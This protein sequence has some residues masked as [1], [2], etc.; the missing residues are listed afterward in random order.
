MQRIFLA[1]FIAILVAIPLI[2]GTPEFWVNQMNTIGIASLVVLGLVILTG[3]AGMT[4]FGQAAFVGMGAYA[5]AYLSTSL[6]YSPWI[7]LLAGLAIAFVIAYILGQITLRLSGH[8]LP[9]GTIALCLIFYYLFGNMDFLGRHDGLPGIVPIEIFGFSLLKA[10]AIYFLIWGVVLLSIFL[11]LNLLNSRTGRAI[12]A[13]KNGAAM[14]ESFGVNTHHYKMIAFVYAALL[15]S[16]AGW[17]YA[18]EQRAVSPSTFGLNYGI[19][20]LFMAVIGG[21]VSIWG[22]ILGA[23][24][25]VFLRDQIQAYTPY[26][27]DAKVNV[28]MVVFGILMVLILHHAKDGLWPIL[29]RGVNKIFGEKQTQNTDLGLDEKA[30]ELPKRERPQ[31]GDTVLRVNKIRKEFGGLVAVNDISF[32]VKAGQI[33]G[34][35]GPNGAGKST[36]FNLITGVLP[37]TSGTVEFMG[38]KISGLSAREISRLGIGRTFQHVQLLPNMTVLENVALGAHLRANSGVVSS[39]LHLE[40]ESEARLLKEAKTQCERVGLGDYLYEKAGNLAL[41]KQR[42]VEIARALALDPTLLLLDE[43][44]AGL[45]YKEKQDLAAVLSA[46]RDEG[47]SILLV[48]HDMDF[49][50]KLTN[51]LVVMDF[52]TYLAEGSPAEIQQNPAVIEA[53]LGGMDDVLDMASPEVKV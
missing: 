48:E 4:S 29:M 28:E 46:L 40:R 21:S 11:S 44:A 37:L 8:F 17:L 53:Y 49:V 38:Q 2:P 12:R 13:L 26:L 1:V 14:A 47:M 6:G 31:K 43:A 19:E 33:M 45:R 20:Y 25:V 27:I 52:G 7:G 30:A 16:V 18:H 50:M 32:E 35:I 36:S 41:G 9:L 22:A 34:L 42:I 51:H 5:T 10:R 3:V 15:A 39:L 23:G 24:L